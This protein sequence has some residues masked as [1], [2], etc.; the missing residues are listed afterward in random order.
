MND[1]ENRIASFYDEESD[2][3]FHLIDN[4]ELL[5]EHYD[6]QCCFYL[7]KESLEKL[8]ELIFARILGEEAAGQ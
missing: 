1:M 2:S 5:V 6:G 7:S 4:G 3:G 8:S